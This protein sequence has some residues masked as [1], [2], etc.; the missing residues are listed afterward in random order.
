MKNLWLSAVKYL[1][2]KFV[3]GPSSSTSST[4]FGSDKQQKYEK[5]RLLLSTDKTKQKEKQKQKKNE[6]KEVG[7][8]FV[9]KF[10]ENDGKFLSTTTNDNGIMI[11]TFRLRG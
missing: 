10:G 7:A 2:E 1:N 4:T 6:E 11:Q 9:V 3:S 5:R 8:R